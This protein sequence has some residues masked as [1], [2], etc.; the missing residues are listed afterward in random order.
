[1]LVILVLSFVGFGSVVLYNARK[2]FGDEKNVSTFGYTAVLAIFG[3][4]LIWPK[5]QEQI[6]SDSQLYSKQSKMARAD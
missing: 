5:L 2:Y 3:N 6:R 1:M 4:L